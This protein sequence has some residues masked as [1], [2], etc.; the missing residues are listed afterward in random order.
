MYTRVYTNAK[1]NNAIAISSLGNRNDALNPCHTCRINTRCVV[2]VRTRP[3]QRHLFQPALKRFRYNGF[4]TYIRG[5]WGVIHVD[6]A[7]RRD[8]DR[9]AADIATIKSIRWPNGFPIKLNE[10]VATSSTSR[11]ELK[12]CG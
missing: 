9:A 6:I 5:G 7:L 10:L 1:I 12:R 8:D 4:A 2:A 11:F 3:A